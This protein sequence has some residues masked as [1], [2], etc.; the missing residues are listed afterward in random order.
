MAQLIDVLRE[1][2]AQYEGSFAIFSKACLTVV[3]YVDSARRNM[4][5][6]GLAQRLELNKPQHPLIFTNW[7]NTY[8]D[9]STYIYRAKGEL[10]VVKKIKKFDEI[11][12][13]N[14]SYLLFVYDRSQNRYDVIQRKEVENLPEKYGMLYD[15]RYIDSL[16]EG[17]R[18]PAN[19]RL[20]NPTCYDENGN[21]GYGRNI[22][23]L[24]TISLHTYEDEFMATESL[25]RD[26]ESTEVDVVKIPINEN[27]VLLNLMGEN[28]EYK[29]FPNIGED[30][31]RKRL[32]AKRTVSRARYPHDMKSSSLRK[33]NDSGRNFFLTGT[34]SDID[35]YC[36]RPREEL[37]KSLTN[38]QLLWYVEMTDRYHQ[39]IV[40]FVEELKDQGANLSDDVK[41]VYGRAKKL[42]NPQKYKIK[43]DG[44]STFD[45]LYM[46]VTV[47]RKQ[48]LLRG[49]KIT[50]RMGNKGVIGTIIK[51]EE[52]F[53]LDNGTRIDLML[54]ALGV[55][56][57]LNTLQLFEQA[58]TF[59]GCRVIEKISETSDI[60]EKENL[61]FTFVKLF[62]PDQ[63]EA[64][65][66]DYR[67]NFTTKKA[68]L[69]YFNVVEQ[70]GI[71]IN[72]PPFW[73]KVSLYEALV[74]CD[75]TF[76]FIERH[77]IYFYD[78]IAGE[79]Q[80]TIFPQPCG[81]V[82]FQKLKQTSQ[83]GFSARGMG[84]IGKKGLPEKSDESKKFLTPYSKVP[85]KI[86]IQENYSKLC[87]IEP[88]V[89]MK[90][91][92]VYRCSPVAR[93]EFAK[94]E[95]TTPGGVKSFTLT[96]EM[97]NRDVDIFYAILLSMGYKLEFEEDRVD[98][99]DTPGEKYHYYRGKH[100]F[101]TSENMKKIISRDVARELLEEKTGLGPIFLGDT[102]DYGQFVNELTEQLAE[103]SF[104]HYI[105]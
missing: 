85:V 79:M 42:L 19:E 101:E 95:L 64:F 28:G 1:K 24:Y 83:K 21:Y 80:E 6:A 70:C 100:Y 26:M 8:G 87:S 89:F 86:G 103:G 65:E 53:Y 92:M 90:E 35:I 74:E 12:T 67:K 56:N 15:N 27:D 51:D 20:F 18:I 55:P 61:L 75:K 13:E 54:D 104:L 43:R 96:Q 39:A 37:R 66:A 50:G 9:H 2:N 99:S 72:V 25:C 91:K 94:R 40:D 48:G 78:P 59:R 84:S 49:Q 62:N 71:A 105:S 47:K 93:K 97:Q 7:E 17:D 98:L 23:C 31:K 58:I 45:Y 22:P 36:N 4:F 41:R 29:S 14:Q 46:E 38:R 81:M 69:E 76:P 88:R 60:K 63:G 10:E 33:T 16:K 44:K 34:V 3:T 52:A 102:S 11:P 32:C 68:K 77:R 57:R 73:Q 30:I 5:N 82:Y